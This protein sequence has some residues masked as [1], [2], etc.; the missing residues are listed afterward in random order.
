VKTWIFTVLIFEVFTVLGYVFT[1]SAR[2]AQHFVALTSGK[3]RRWRRCHGQYN[4]AL[5]TW[6]VR[7]VW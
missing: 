5:G 6:Q 3:V 1:V 2:F 7:T 4:A